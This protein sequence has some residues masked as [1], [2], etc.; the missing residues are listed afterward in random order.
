MINLVYQ[1][2]IDVKDNDSICPGFE[3]VLKTLIKEHLIHE[4]LIDN[5]VVTVKEVLPYDII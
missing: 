3:D 1:V 4:E 5:P 2:V